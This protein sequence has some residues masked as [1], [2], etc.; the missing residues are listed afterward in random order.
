[1]DLSPGNESEPRIPFAGFINLVV[2]EMAV[3]SWPTLAVVLLYQF[4]FFR[5]SGQ[6]CLCDKNI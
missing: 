1:M 2:C 3:T 4:Y 6:S 5:S